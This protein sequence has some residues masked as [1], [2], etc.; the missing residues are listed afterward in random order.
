LYINYIHTH[1]LATAWAWLA[2]VV[3]LIVAS[4]IIF[5]VVEQWIFGSDNPRYPFPEDEM[6]RGGVAR[7]FVAAQSQVAE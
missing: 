1:G 6:A 2:A 5:Q 7:K 3:Y 4:F